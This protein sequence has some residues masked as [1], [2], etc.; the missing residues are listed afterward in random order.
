MTHID[1]LIIGILHLLDRFLFIA[2]HPFKSRAISHASKND[3]RHLEIVSGTTSLES[4]RK[5]LTF[6]PDFPKLTYSIVL[7]SRI[8]VFWKRETFLNCSLGSH[9]SYIDTIAPPH[10]PITPVVKHTGLRCQFLWRLVVEVFRKDQRKEFFR[11]D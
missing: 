10:D 7:A 11:G 8:D 3:F 1:A 2:N 5:R 6:R 9:T 4:I